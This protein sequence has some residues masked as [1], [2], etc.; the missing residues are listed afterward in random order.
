MLRH[1]NRHTHLHA[2]STIY[3]HE[4]STS[5]TLPTILA[6]VPK[7]TLWIAPTF[8]GKL[9]SYSNM[10]YAYCYHIGSI[11]TWGCLSQYICI[12]TYIYTSYWFLHWDIPRCDCVLIQELC[13]EHTETYISAL[14]DVLVNSGCTK[15]L[16]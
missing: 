9:Q 7:L 2:M 1:D 11:Y 13:Y 16:L 12:H 3:V 6:K 10:Y 4:Y 5:I 15:L 14:T 8:L